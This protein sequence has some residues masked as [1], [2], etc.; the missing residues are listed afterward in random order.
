MGVR[1]QEERDTLQKRRERQKSDAS[2]VGEAWGKIMKKNQMPRKKTAQ[3]KRKVVFQPLF[4]SG[5]HVSFPVDYHTRC[6]DVGMS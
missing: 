5:W 4:C 2:D 6:W 3:S 1:I